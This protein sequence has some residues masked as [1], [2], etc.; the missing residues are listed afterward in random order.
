MEAEAGED[1][2]EVFARKHPQ[3]RHLGHGLQFHGGENG[4]IRGETQFCKILAFEVERNSVLY[5][6]TGMDEQRVRVLV[7]VEP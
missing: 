4:R 1:P 6:N 3:F 7:G 2:K 5:V